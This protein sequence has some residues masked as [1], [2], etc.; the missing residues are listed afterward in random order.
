MGGWPWWVLPCPLSPAWGHSTGDSPIIQLFSLLILL[1]LSTVLQKGNR[2]FSWSGFPLML[3]LTHAKVG[4]VTW[5]S[6][7]RWQQDS[8]LTNVLVSLLQNKLSYF[9]LTLTTRCPCCY[10]YSTPQYG[11][12]CDLMVLPS[13][14]YGSLGG[15]G[16]SGRKKTACPT[17]RL[18]YSFPYSIYIYVCL[19]GYGS[20]DLRLYTST[21]QKIVNYWFYSLMHKKQNLCL[22][23]I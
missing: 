14:S 1:P 23:N 12:S 5:E 11:S 6:P 22:N 9:Y 20:T 2:E 10:P 17:Q 13:C 3:V 8:Y 16:L 15:M 18:Q 7:H 4:R 21:K 19:N